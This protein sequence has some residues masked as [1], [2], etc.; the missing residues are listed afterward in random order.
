MR[1]IC[2]VAVTLVLS[3]VT[4]TGFAQ[5]HYPEKPI[6]M[7]VPYPPGSGTDTVA[8]YTARRLETALKQP[9]VIENKPG[10][11]AIIAAQSVIAAAPDG[12]T[13]LWAANGPV[14]TNVALFEKLP[15]DPLVDLVPVARTAYSPMGVFVPSTSPYK[16]VAELLAAAKSQPGKLNYAA[17][18]ATYSIATEWLMSESGGKATGVNYKGAAPA[19][20]DVAG[21]QVDF[22]I[23]ELSAGL[24]LVAANKVKLLAVNS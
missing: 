24:P 14:T 23:V 16:T 11:S 18:S 3:T 8:R 5:G 6:K 19:M 17:G 9:V 10:A 21:G 4:L 12:Y 22:T 20:A 13:L 2:K 7:I 1:V 15:Y